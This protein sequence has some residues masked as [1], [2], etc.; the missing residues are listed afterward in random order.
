MEA[1][2]EIHNFIFD[3]RPHYPLLIT[4]KRYR[5]LKRVVFRTTDTSHGANNDPLTLVFAHGAG[6]HKEQYE[7][8]IEDLWGYVVAGSSV[9]RKGEV[10]GGNMR[11][12]REIWSLDCPNHGDAAILNE[13][14][15]MYGYDS[16]CEFV[17]LGLT[18]CRETY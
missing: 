3:P 11:E 13:H 2:F 14:T 18:R 4:A 12:I 16:H 6:F 9:E 10:E 8:T 1:N 5:P 17:L 7:A 15:V